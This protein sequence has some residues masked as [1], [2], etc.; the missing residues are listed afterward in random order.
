MKRF[1]LLLNPNARGS[2][3]KALRKWTQSFGDVFDVYESEPAE[4]VRDWIR[5]KVAQGA[6][7]IVAAGGDGT[8]NL[9]AEE[10]VGTET[11]MGII[12]AGTMNVFARELRFPLK[13]FD[14]ALKILHQGKIREIDVFTANG[15]PFLQMCGVGFDAQV[16]SGVTWEN[17][18][19]WGPLAYV[20][21]AFRILKE[22]PSLLKIT[23]PG[24]EVREGVFAVMGNGRF[25]GGSFSLFPQAEPDD[26]FLDILL[27]KKLGISVIGQFLRTL[28]IPSR[29]PDSSDIEYHRVKECLVESE[30]KI[31]FELDGDARGFTPVEI[32]LSPVKLKIIVP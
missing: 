31:P 19:R 14:A 9:L 13:N 23:L 22:K 4:N 8:L 12:P 6:P 30:E 24:G 1:P 10:L 20:H 5:G 11:V 18:K 25:Y 29:S 7:V 2:H 17:K 28:F 26:G 16:V 27:F 15:N 32:K 3:S 21:S